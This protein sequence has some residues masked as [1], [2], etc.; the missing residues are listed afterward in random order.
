MTMLNLKCNIYFVSG[1]ILHD[2]AVPSETRVAMLRL[3]AFGAGQDDIVLILH[4]DRK[5]HLVMN[6]AQDFDLLP[7]FEQEAVALFVSIVCSDI[8]LMIHYIDQSVF[9][10][11]SSEPQFIFYSLQTCLRQTRQANGCSTY[12][13]GHKEIGIYPTSV[14]QRKLQ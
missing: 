7:I 1:R 5:D 3:M 8:I 10:Y 9:L 14:L 4:S 6:Y 11:P 12:Q 13:N 2:K